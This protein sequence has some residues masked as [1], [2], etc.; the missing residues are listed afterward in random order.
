MKIEINT[1]RLG[2]QRRQLKRIRNKLSKLSML[3]PNLTQHYH[4][5]AKEKMSL[6]LTKISK[7]MH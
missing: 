2:K 1:G 5:S 4:L 6:L 3:Y 7:M